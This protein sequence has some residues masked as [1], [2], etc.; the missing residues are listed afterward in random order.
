MAPREQ[1]EAD[2]GV[3]VIEVIQDQTGDRAEAVDAEC[4][5]RAAVALCDDLTRSGLVI[6]GAAP[7]TCTFVVN[8]ETI[9]QAVPESSLWALGVL[10]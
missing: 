5:V 3:V 9:R 4:A 8:G 10:A 6:Q 2:P 1:R 7:L